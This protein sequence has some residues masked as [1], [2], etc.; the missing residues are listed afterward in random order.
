MNRDSLAGALMLQ[1]LAALMAALILRALA[2][3]ADPL[4]RY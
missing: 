4:Q 1:V 2:P 3:R